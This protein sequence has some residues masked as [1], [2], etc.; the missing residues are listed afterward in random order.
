MHVAV[1]PLCSHS[2]VTVSLPTVSLFSVS[3]FSVP[4]FV[5]SLSSVLV[6]PQDAKSEMVVTIAKS[7]M[8]TERYF[9]I[10]C[11]PI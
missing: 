4:L 6:F 9:F 11:P 7:I 10:L 2:V 1:P 5:I 3:L 8:K